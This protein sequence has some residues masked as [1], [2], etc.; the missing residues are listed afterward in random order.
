MLERG[1]RL[2]TI[3]D[4]GIFDGGE[5]VAFA[6]EAESGDRLALNC[7]LPEL[8]DIFC[9]LGMLAKGAGEARNL[10]EPGSQGQQDYL[11][12]IPAVGIAFQAGRSA[13]ETLLIMR[14][15]GFDL[16]FAVPS[17]GLARLADDIARIART[18]SA[19]HGQPN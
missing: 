5:T 13:D 9:T 8:G 2:K 11:A 3:T 15:S 18:L 10:P 16:A 1:S 12:P 17:D 7:S 6:I 14:L 4:T 19:G